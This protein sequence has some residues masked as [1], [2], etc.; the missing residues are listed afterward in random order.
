MP[1]AVPDV[2]SPRAVL[3]LCQ[4]EVCTVTSELYTDDRGASF[5]YAPRLPAKRANSGPVLAFG[6]EERSRR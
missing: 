1:S 2:T 6:R 4:R 5:E 3:Q